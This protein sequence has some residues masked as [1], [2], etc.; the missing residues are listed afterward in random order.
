MKFNLQILLILF[1]LPSILWGAE[2]ENSNSK[3]FKKSVALIRTYQQAHDWLIPW[4]KKALR[5]RNGAAL[6]L[7]QQQLLTTAGLVM[8][9][10]LIEVRKPGDDRPYEAEVILADNAINLALLHVSD[11]SFWDDLDP[12][13]WGK[14]KLG[15]SKIQYWESKNEW[16]SISGKVKQL[17]I[18]YRSQSKA[19]F[20][21]FEVVASLKSKVQGNPL[22][23]NNKITGMIMQLRDSNLDA[24][25][26]SFL[27]TFIKKASEKPYSGFPQR[28]FG[29]QQITQDALRSHLSI[30]KSQTGILIDRIFHYGTGSDVLQINDFLVSMAGKKLSNEGKIEH[31]EWGNVLFDFLFTDQPQNF[32]TFSLEVIRQGK[33]LSLE[34][35]LEDF[36][37][38]K[39]SVPLKTVEH[40]P[41]YVLRGGVLFQE[42]NMNYLEIWGKDW[43]SKAP[44][45]L[46]IYQQ[47]ESHLPVNKNRRLVLVTRV[48][49]TSINI[50][51]QNLRSLIVTEINGRPVH[52]LE[53][54]K[55]AFEN[56]RDGFHQVNFMPGSNRAYLI[57]PDA[58]MKAT[59]QQILQHFQIPHLE[60]LSF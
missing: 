5:Q 48:L 16:K 14:T 11:P 1:V 2:P 49:P 20:P 9:H 60:R 28:G 33:R 53:D 17:F 52:R 56:P 6:V 4:N 38:E 12:V 22:V 25:P 18:G 37:A 23:Q 45:R 15:D 32:E 36:P 30:E 24:F 26:A 59:D 27:Q 54:V 42:L 39:Y 43:T 7:P 34:T 40:P 55:T 10:T 21:V 35:H 3:E 57:L 41:R 50:G 51:Y 31:S 44:A 13:E 29:W 19:H 58:E 47:L 8:N 46:S